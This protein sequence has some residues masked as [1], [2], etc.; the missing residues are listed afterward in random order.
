VTLKANDSANPP[1]LAG[2]IDVTANVD[3]LTLKDL[4]LSGDAGASRTLNV[5]GG[6]SLSDVTI[7][8][9]TFDGGDS[10]DAAIYGNSFSGNITIID[11]NV[12][13]Y[14]GDHWSL[15]YLGGSGL[16]SVEIMGST[17]QDSTGMVGSGEISNSV[18]VEDNTFSGIEQDSSDSAAA[19]LAL[20]DPA[21][22][23]SATA[24]IS[25][26]TFSDNFNH[27]VLSDFDGETIQSVVNS[28]NFDR[29]AYGQVP[30]PK[31]VGLSVD[32]QSAHEN[33][34]WA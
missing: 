1:E 8:N 19:A 17:V 24:S 7:D 14:T 25:G 6:G 12:S 11:S 26:N 16:D 31:G 10:L 4:K 28:N 30:T 27:V 32:S 2:G 29:T 5:A 21:L 33:S 9:V 3:G 34:W 18:T 13:D 20:G 22:G 23:D 15:V